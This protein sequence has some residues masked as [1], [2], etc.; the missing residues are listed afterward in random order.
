MNSALSTLIKKKAGELG[1]S[2]I[3][4]ARAQPL[5]VEAERLEAWLQ[6]GYHASMSWM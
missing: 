5:D 1:F 6:R 3:G 4:F 2:K